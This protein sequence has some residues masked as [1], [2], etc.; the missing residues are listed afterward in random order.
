MIAGFVLRLTRESIP[1]TQAGM[2]E[3]LGVDL[4]TVQGRESG[5]R[6]LANMKAG[7]LLD[8]RRRL[9]ALGAD[10]TALGL[11]DAA[12]D[13]D[14][15]IGAALDP[16]EQPE[17]HPLAGWVHT[18]DTAHM[19]AW[20][21]NGTPPPALRR[22]SPSRRGPVAGAPLMGTQERNAFFS[23]LRSAVERA[24]KTGDGRALLHRQALYLTSYDCSSEA[25]SWT[26]H[27]LHARRGLVA[28]QGGSPRWAGAR[29]T[30][31]ALARRGDPVPLL[32]FIDRSIADDDAAEAANLNYW[33]YWLG[34]LREPQPS[35]A[36]MDDRA[37]T[38]WD[39]VT[40]LRGLAQGFHES[41]GYVDLYAHSL[42]AL[43]TAHRWLPQASPALARTLAGRVA[44]ILETGS[45]SLRSRRELSAVH[46][47]LRDQKP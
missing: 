28:V 6:P 22:P 44:R 11:L 30:A 16:P 1:L 29:S 3:A 23:H 43:L 8:L 36:F 34:A 10:Q 38:G 13:A 46:Y 25:N 19:I 26:A 39:P 24:E 4:G 7:A 40:L 42:W 2:A 47:V 32:D 41:P 15:I 14:R 9:L 5:R 12:M 45:I 35:D 20:A 37:L 33:A 18:R 21:V 17:L 27:A 31:T